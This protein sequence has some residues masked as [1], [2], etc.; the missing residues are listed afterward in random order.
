MQIGQGIFTQRD[1]TGRGLRRRAGGAVT[2]ERVAEDARTGG[3]CL[4]EDSIVVRQ[5]A[6]LLANGRGQWPQVEHGLG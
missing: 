2:F 6:D 5:A 4:G 1:V 3:Q